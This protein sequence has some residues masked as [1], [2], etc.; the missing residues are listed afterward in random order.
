VYTQPPLAGVHIT[1]VLRELESSDMAS[2]PFSPG[3]SE[4]VSCGQSGLVVDDIANLMRM[5]PLPKRNYI[6]Q[7]L[8]FNS[9][10]MQMRLLSVAQ[11][12]A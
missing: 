3:L 11:A 12:I 4:C 1:F 6:D 9:S 5:R 8:P 2:I 10:G 7:R